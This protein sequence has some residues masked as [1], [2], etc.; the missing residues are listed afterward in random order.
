MTDEMN[1][2]ENATGFLKFRA[3]ATPSFRPRRHR[4]R[5][6]EPRVL[7]LAMVVEFDATSGEMTP[8]CIPSLRCGVWV[9]ALAPRARPE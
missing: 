9:P 6:P 7:M 3:E 4:R 8:G 1:A 2:R 5:E